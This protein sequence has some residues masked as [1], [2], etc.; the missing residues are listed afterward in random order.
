MRFPSLDLL[1]HTARAAAARFPMVL[2]AS[3]VA[4]GSASLLVE[5]V[6][7]ATYFQRYLAAATLGLPLFLAVSL[8]AERRGWTDWRR[9]ITW[10]VG[11]AALAL[12]VVLWP[13]WSVPVQLRRYVQLSAAFH[14]LAAFLPYAGRREPNGFWQYNGALL[15]RAVIAALYAVVLYGGLAIAVGALD[16]LFGVPVPDN[17]YGHLWFWTAF[18]VTTWVFIAGVPADFA[19]LDAK[20]D[21]PKGLKTFAQFILIPIVLVYLVILTAYLAKVVI[22]TEWPSGWIGYLVSSVAVVGILSVLL[23]HPVAERAEN[24]WVATY[25][26]WF[27]VGMIPA[28]V[29]LLLAIGQRVAQYGITENRYFMTGLAVWLAVIAAYYG[30]TRSRNIKLIPI[31]LCLG[32]LATLGGP[33]GAY[34]VSERSQVSRLRELLATNGMWSEGAARPAGER[35]VSFEDRREISAVFRYLAETHG[36]DAIARWFGSEPPGW[37]V[38]VADQWPETH[39]QAAMEWLD[40][41]YVARWE[42]QG[43]DQWVSFMPRRSGPAGYPVATYDLLVMLDG[44]D[45]DTV[46]AEGYTVVMDSSS[47]VLHLALADA[48]QS[49]LDFALDTLAV[50]ALARDQDSI[51]PPIV[52]TARREGLSATLIVQRLEGWRRDGRFELANWSAGLLI[53][54]PP[55]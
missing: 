45:W 4:A 25:V 35:E 28:I 24:R 32:T 31:S 10:V 48:P 5:E 12:V 55:R 52:L 13:R 18:V 33:W 9:A 36:M 27:Y 20:T 46:R 47:R 43:R 21:Y 15:G 54:G 11:V 17:M 7:G 8:F 39:A 37:A 38:A 2:L 41:A 53:A 50:L 14:L 49:T 29:M 34:A 1:W 26:R 42:G 19:A 16:R 44:K 6:G 30:V 23:I 3:V 22:T 40:L 51:R